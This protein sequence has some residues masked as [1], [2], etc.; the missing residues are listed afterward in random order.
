MRSPPVHRTNGFVAALR[1]V[2]PGSQ[3]GARGTVR[4]RS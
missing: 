2:L 1:P 4:L 3:G